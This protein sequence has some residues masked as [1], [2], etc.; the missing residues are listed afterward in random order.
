MPVPSVVPRLHDELRVVARFISPPGKLDVNLA[1]I[2]FGSGIIPGEQSQDDVLVQL[3][4]PAGEGEGVVPIANRLG[5]ENLRAIPPTI[6]EDNPQMKLAVFVN[7][8]VLFAVGKVVW[9]RANA[10]FASLDSS[11]IT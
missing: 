5:C 2:V 6:P 3:V 11:G 8:G 1:V 4:Y 9:P 10:G 7:P